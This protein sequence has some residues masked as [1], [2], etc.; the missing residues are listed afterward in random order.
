MTNDTAPT[1]VWFRRDFRVS[2]NPALLAAVERGTPA[3]CVYIWSPADWGEWSP[4]AASRWWL[5]HSLERLDEHLRSLGSRLVIRSGRS[6]S[7]LCDL[8]RTTGAGAVCWNRLYEPVRREEEAGVAET[9]R[10]IGVEVSTHNAALLFEPWA[11][12]TQQGDPYKVFT[13]FW[14]ACRRSDDPTPPCPAPKQLRKPGTWPESMSLDDLK[15]LP[16]VDW[17]AGIRDAWTPGSNAAAEQLHRFLDEALGDYSVGRN[18]PDLAGVSRLSPYLHFGEISPRTVWHAVKQRVGDTDNAAF[19]QSADTF[20]AELGWREFAHHLLYHF[21]HTIDEPLRPEFGDFSWSTDPHR[22]DAWQRGRTGYPIVDAG[23]R[24][25]WH[26]GWMHNRVRMV[27]ASFLVKDLLIDW[28][29]GARWFW[30]TLVDA[31]PANNTLGW[32]WTAGCGADAAP[33]FRI[34]NPDTQSQ[35][36]DP[37]GA[38]VR[39][40]VPELGC[41][42][43]AWIHQPFAAPAHVLHQA[44]VVLG[45]TYPHPIVDHAEA[46]K[47]ALAAYDAVKRSPAN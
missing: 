32:Q 4:G 40:W 18:R 25:L 22:L 28:R 31:D 46:R 34:F 26:T 21:P 37:D 14:R 7:V 38:Y 39:R 8:V 9:L 3:I 45:D 27:V 1:I 47:E 30:D 44:G 19:Q 16:E 2:D 29:D 20:L 41:L 12:Q 6:A 11:I 5:H 13:P 43:N 15:L 24:E 36:F 33:Y 10:D 23:M 17:A 35:R 42:P